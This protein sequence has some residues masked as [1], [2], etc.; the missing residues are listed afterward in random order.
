MCGT[1]DEEGRAAEDA[2]VSHP[3]VSLPCAVEVLALQVVA[4]FP[5][6]KDELEQKTQ[7]LC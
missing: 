1:E 6:G 4:A 3:D 5:C 2:V 7:Q